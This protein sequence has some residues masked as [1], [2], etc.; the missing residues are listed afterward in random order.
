MSHAALKSDANREL[1]L[2][3]LAHINHVLPAHTILSSFPQK[4]VCGEEYIT[5]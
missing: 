3:A 2:S 4:E 1:I 5:A